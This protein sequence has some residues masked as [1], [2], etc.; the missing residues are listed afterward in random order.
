MEQTEIEIFFVLIAL[1]IL[2]FIIGILLFIFQY[3][4]KR[5]S[6]EREKFE[7]EKQHKLDLLN[8]Q[9]SVQQQTMQFIGGEI[10]DSVAQKITLASIY[11]Q[12][13]EYE[14]GSS[15]IAGKL[16]KINAILSDSLLELRELAKTLAYDI[17]NDS[18][19][20]LVNREKEKV[21]EMGLCNMTVVSNFSQ[22][23]G[24]TTKSFLLRVIQEFIQN[25]LK[26]SRCRII[27]VR[28]A[29]EKGGLLVEI[30]DDGIG[31]DSTDL[32]REGIGLNNMKRRVHMLGGSFRL[33][34]EP[35]RG[36]SLEIFIDNNKL[37][38]E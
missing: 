29:E 33:N 20:E 23:I 9:L 1:I 5:L 8:N 24:V 32:H 6:Y 37:L 19:N 4:R 15:V 17:R 28:L 38:S 25:S 34:S 18:L 14:S 22:E 30:A 2:I 31:F 3:R 21:A 11:C 12:K 16:K 26:H 27:T 13:L 10:H 35:G 36:T 7:T